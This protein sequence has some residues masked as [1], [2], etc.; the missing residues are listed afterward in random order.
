MLQSGLSLP[1]VKK[2]AVAIRNHVTI[3]MK[4]AQINLA[5]LERSEH[6]LASFRMPIEEI[7]S[8]RVFEGHVRKVRTEDDLVSL[9]SAQSRANCRAMADHIF[10]PCQ[11]T[12]V[13]SATGFE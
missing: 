2:R 7:L 13:E 4:R 5:C 11:A 10:M 9:L 8:T 6:V 1:S 3:R 12:V